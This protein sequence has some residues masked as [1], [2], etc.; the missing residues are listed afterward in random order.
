MLRRID[1]S[2]HRNRWRDKS[3]P[4]AVLCAGLML[5]ALLLPPWPGALLTG[6]VALSAAVFGARV[7]ARV[8]M[9]SMVVPLGFVLTSGLVLCLSLRWENG[10]PHLVFT[11]AGLIM[12]VQAGSRALAAVAVM[13]LLALTVPLAQQLAMLR[14]LQVPEVLLD[15]MLLTYRTIFLLDDCRREILRAQRNRL[16][17][18]TARLALQSAGLAAGAL[19]RRALDRAARMERGLAARGYDGRLAVLL[20][21]AQATRT[22]YG[23][24]IALPLGVGLATG[25]FHWLP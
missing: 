7:P 23:L 16:G 14:R 13:L 15:L 12:A 8:I 25:L 1:T 24:A 10:G 22:D 9:R 20:P 19:F 18:R 11:P 5:C 6:G 17:Y 2:A 3:R 4:V 21:P